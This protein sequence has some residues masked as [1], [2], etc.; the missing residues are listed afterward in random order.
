MFL[1]FIDNTKK[2]IHVKMLLSQPVCDFATQ[3]IQK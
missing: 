2:D 3:N 1:L